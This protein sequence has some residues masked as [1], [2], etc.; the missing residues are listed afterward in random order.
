MDLI[1]AAVKALRAKRA[2]LLEKQKKE[3]SVTD[4]YVKGQHFCS[5][6][7]FFFV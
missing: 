7:S 3:R 2:E 5:L 1:L 4:F 6:S